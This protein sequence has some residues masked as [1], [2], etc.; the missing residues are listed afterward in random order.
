MSPSFLDAASLFAWCRIPTDELEIHPDKK[1]ALRILETPD[2]VHRW[3]AREMAQ[4][5][6]QNN[7]LKKPTR[8]ILPCG[9]TKQY[10]YFIKTVNEERI[11][12]KN[13]HVFHMDNFLDWQGRL[14]PTD[15]PFN[16]ETWMRRN[17]YDPVDPELAIPEEHRHFPSV[18]QIDEISEK[19]VQSG[20]IDTTYGGVGYRGHIAFNEPPRSAWYSISAPEFRDSKTRILNL[21]DDTLIALSQ[22][23]AGGCSHAIPPMAIT[24]GMKDLLSARRIRIISDTGAWKQ[25]V[26]RVLLFGPTTIEYPVTFIQNHPDAMIVIDRLTAAPPLGE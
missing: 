22:R 6:K 9:P 15:H 25:T 5:V 13:V 24:L 21:N 7:S 18:D 20:G 19:I 12:L 26:V 17:F 10:P 3:A 11:N 8:W 4:E 1:V 23:L 16:Y 14:L 2:D